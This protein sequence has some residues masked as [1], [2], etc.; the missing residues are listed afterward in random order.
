MPF[1]CCC[2]N[3]DNVCRGSKGVPGEVPNRAQISWD[4]AQNQSSTRDHP[5]V[6][7]RESFFTST[8]LE[9]IAIIAMDE[10]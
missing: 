6:Q 3:V 7:I 9:P 1:K 10:P 2:N 5:M 8:G 4:G